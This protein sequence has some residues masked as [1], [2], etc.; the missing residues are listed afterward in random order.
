MERSSLQRML[1]DNAILRSLS[2]PVA[3]QVAP[4]LHRQALPAGH[5]LFA[6]G[7][8]V[9]S[10]YFPVAGAVSLVTELSSGDLIESAIVGRDGVV[11]AG[12]TLDD[13]DAM[14]RAVVQIDSTGYSLD[15]DSARQ[16]ARE[17]EP[18]R[19]ALAR[20][21]QLILAQAQQAAACNAKHNLQQRLARWL[22]RVR[23]AT[24]SDNFVLTQ[25]FMAEMLGVRRSSLTLAA[26]SLQTAGLIHYRRGKITIA[27]LE[28]LQEAACECY[29]TVR[30]RYAALLQT[31]SAQHTRLEGAPR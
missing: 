19:T 12:A 17:S 26:Q 7:N 24:G 15:M 8:K 31:D 27:R 23:D 9:A 18:F 3:E 5:V 22:L 13:R 1:S 16:F 10:V 29:S 28:L 4:R 21:E 25:E 6:E 11:G 30:E 14:Y 20:N 2:G